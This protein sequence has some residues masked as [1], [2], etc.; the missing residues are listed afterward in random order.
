[1]TEIG[2]MSPPAAHA[3]AARDL[4][5]LVDEDDAGLL[6]ALDRGATH[7]LHVDQSALFLPDK[8]LHRLG[9]AQT[10]RFRAA[11]KE[12]AHHVLQVDANFFD[13]GTGDDLE[14]RHC[15]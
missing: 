9:N 5:D 14:G 6:D 4:V 12:I 8:V 1:A 13:R 10:A 11:L 3:V 7:G 2:A 15:G